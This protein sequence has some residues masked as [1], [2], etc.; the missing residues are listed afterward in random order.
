[1]T[2]EGVGQSLGELCIKDPQPSHLQIFSV[3]SGISEHVQ[4]ARLMASSQAAGAPHC[5]PAARR[6]GS[7]CAGI[8]LPIMQP[9]T[10]GQAKKKSGR[11]GILAR[12]RPTHFFPARILTE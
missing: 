10:N 7:G 9:L 3:Q 8:I 6:T 1:M 4:L 12:A 11:P 5:L 2:G